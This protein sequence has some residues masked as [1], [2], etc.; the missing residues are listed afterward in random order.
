[1]LD[2]ASKPITT[3]LLVAA[4]SAKR[5]PQNRWLALLT[6]VFLLVT[7]H[8]SLVTAQI[9]PP[10][11]ITTVAGT[12]WTYSGGG[13]AVNAPLGLVTGVV[14]DSAGNLFVSDWENH[15]VSKV[16]PTGT[17][18]VVAG[19]GIA[20]FSGDGGLA[21]NA[22]LRSPSGLAFDGAANLFIADTGNHRVRKVSPAG[23]I[24]TVAGNGQAF[25]SGDG[26]PATSAAVY[27]PQGVAVDA[28]GN[29]YI[30]DYNYNRVRRVRPDGIITTFAGGVGSDFNGGGF[31]GDGG[32]ASN[33]ALRAPQGVATDAAGNVYIADTGNG[34]IRKVSPGGIIS[35][36]AGNGNCCFAGD[37]GPAVNAFLGSPSAVT[38]DVAGSLYIADWGDQ[39]IRKVS[40]NGIITTVAGDGFRDPATGGGRF[41]GDG[42]VA[43]NASLNGPGGVA[44]DPA[45]NFFIA[46]GGNSRA[47]KVSQSGIITTVAGN[48]LF[49]FAG[50]GGPASTAALNIPQ[51]VALDAGGNLYIAD[52]YNNR[53]RKV[54]PSRVISTVAG[55]GIRGFAGDGG[56]ATSA[57]LHH[58]FGVAFDSLGN[59][60]ISD[61]DN[62][63]IRKV[64]PDGT[65]TTV[66]GGGLNFPGDGGPATSA[67]V[68][69]TYGV[70]VDNRGNI[71]IANHDRVRMV[72]PGGIISTVAG[73][74]NCCFAGDGGPAGN[75]FLG[76]PSAATAVEAGSR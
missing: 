17:L 36:V 48:G 14:A 47:R 30:T 10:S 40:P 13:P 11:I 20:G 32:P 68:N 27:L 31:S 56:P 62:R 29:L 5:C 9:T 7:C 66:A 18:T 57:S 35:T 45:G 63:R 43:T 23:I 38:V 61:S 46:D 67:S 8:S 37:G 75:A 72:S 73:N 39:R 34:R 53:I 52:Y 19:N 12:T 25:F 76:S 50:D 26:G 21:T 65:I 70:V 1:M 55:N 49:R 28:V 15:L 44:V 6:S 60:Y 33:A 16:S 24:T 2:R 74:G 69:Q 71:Y 42:G 64:R 22:Q 51:G 58:P 54:S 41:A 59:L 3:L 4:S